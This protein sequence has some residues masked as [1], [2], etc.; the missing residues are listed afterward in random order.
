MSKHK[1]IK[2]WVAMIDNGWVHDEAQVKCVQVDVVETPKQFR[3]SGEGS[4]PDVS[5]AIRSCGYKRHINKNNNECLWNTREQALL[6]LDAYLCKQEQQART[7]WDVA[8]ENLYLIS[9][10]LKNESC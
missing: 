2:K 10:A 4:D 8:T 3:I 1:T 5:L 6:S 7:R 9:E